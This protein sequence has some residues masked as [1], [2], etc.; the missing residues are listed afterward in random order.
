MDSNLD[1]PST[2]KGIAVSGPSKDKVKR[3]Y[4]HRSP[5]SPEH[6]NSS[7]P[8]PSRG[9]PGKISEHQPRRKDDGKE[10]NNDSER[11]YRHSD[12]QS[13]NSKGYYAHP[14]YIKDEKH[15]DDEERINQK[16]TFHPGRE[17]R[18]NTHFDPVRSRN[19]SRYLNKDSQDKYDSFE[20]RSRDKDR[21]SRFLDYKKYKDDSLSERLGSGKSV[22]HF[23]D[24]ES[25][26]YRHRADRDSQD[27]KR[28]YRRSSRS[29]RNFSYEE[30][31]GHRSES[32]SRRDDIKHRESEGYKS[33]LK[34]MDD[35]KLERDQ[36]K[37]YDDTETKRSKDQ[38]T[39]EPTESYENKD[40]CRSQD[41]GSAAKRSKFY[42]LDRGIAGQEDVSKFTTTSDGRDSSSS[43][44]IQDG[45]LENDINAAKVAAMKAAELVN[46]N[47]AGAGPAGCLTADQK[48][49]LLW[50]NKKNTTAEEAG[51]RWDTALFPDRERQEKF[52]KL[53]SLRLPWCLW[54]I[55]GCEGGSEVGAEPQ[56]PREHRSSQSREAEG[57]PA[58]SR[59]A[60][61]SWIEKKR[62]P[63]CWFRSLSILRFY[64]TVKT[65]GYSVLL[66]CHSCAY[67]LSVGLTW[68][69]F[70][71]TVNLRSIL[72]IVFLLVEFLYSFVCVLSILLIVF[73]HC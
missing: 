32:I 51:H 37:K 56:Q 16:S 14:D 6:N 13:R 63:H 72:L 10:L 57:T 23:E 18:G 22:G 3:N 5:G 27:E 39:K 42:N 36:R 58:G 33:H 45:K 35:E 43:K 2:D 49:K 7:S 67:H 29:E 65:L 60:V 9:D 20:H 28:D 41:Q 31:M 24:M 68:N 12:R 52:K 21:G 70:Y 55:V 8:K 1:P 46:R 11:S 62:W 26:R 64:C 15:A 73:Q 71:C 34:E 30:S 59:E 53:M 38:I 19:H 61:Y 69:I 48:K 4:R 40:M 54:P 47:L 25:E 44:Q 66:L 50:G 17:S